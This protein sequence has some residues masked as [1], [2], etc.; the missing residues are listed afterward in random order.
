[1][2]PTQIVAARPLFKVTL[3]YFCLYYVFCFFQGLS[4]VFLYFT[5]RKDAN[6]KAP[7]LR[8]HKYESKRGL[9]LIA[10]RTFGNMVEQAPPFLTCLWM[11]GLVFDPKHA[12]AAGWWY[13]GFRAIYPFVFAL[14]APW[15]FISTLANYA[16]IGLMMVRVLVRV[17]KAQA[18][19]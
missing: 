11:Y 7:S 16:V 17:R 8:E 13:I 4:K 12:A 2:T 3:A 6:G 1:M 19:F 10:D 5:T 15:L 14:G 18:H 9:G